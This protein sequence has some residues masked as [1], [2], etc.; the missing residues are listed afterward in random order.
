MN[1]CYLFNTAKSFIKILILLFEH[2]LSMVETKE[3][4]RP[5]RLDGGLEDIAK[6]SFNP[7]LLLF[8][9]G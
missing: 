4:S 2:V 3:V 9:G 5:E 7:P 1:N 6:K 8:K